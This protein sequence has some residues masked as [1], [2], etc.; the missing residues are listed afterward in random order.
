M[1]IEITRVYALLLIPI[2]VLIFYLI[3]K[4][5]KDVIRR[6]KFVLISRILILILIIAGISDITI[7]LRGKNVETV[8]LLDVSD[9]MSEFKDE[10]LKFIDNSLKEQPNHNKCGVILFGN[11]ASVDKSM[12][13]NKEYREIKSLPISIATNIEEAINTSFSLFNKGSSKRIVLITD[14]EENKGDMLKSVNLLKK[15]NVDL[16]VYKV[17]NALGDEVYIDEVSVPDNIA[18]DEE[19]SV[20]TKIQSNVQTKVKLT[21]FSGREKK[22]EQEVQV[23][24][25]INTFVFKDIQTSGGFKPYR[26]LIEPEKDS[27]SNNNEYS[28]FTNV[29]S[30]P[31]ILVIEGNEN[32]ALGVIETLRA[33]NSEFTTISP[34]TSP[35]TLNEMLEYKTIVL[36]DVHIDDLSSGFVDNIETYVKDYGGGLVTF[37]GENSYAL[38][39]Y[40]DTNLEKV[41]PVNMDKKGK[42]EIPQISISLVIDKSGSMSS[43]DGKVSKL[44]LAKEA[45][46]KSLDNLRETD[47]ISVI[48]FDDKYQRV[49]ERQNPK[50]KEEIKE[51]ISGIGEGGGTSIYPALEEAYKIQSESGAKIK[52]II[53]LTDGQDGFGLSNYEE[54]INNINNG[55]ITLSTV[56]VGED[57]DSYLLEELAVRGQGRTYHTDGFTDIPRIFAKEVLLST[58]TYIINEEFTPK[59]VSNNEVLSGVIND[60]S[61]PTLLGYIGTSTKDKA[62][63]V[64]SSNH[65][66]PILAIWQYGLGKSASWTSDINGQWSGHFLTW[67]KGA[68]LFK[69]I[70]YSTIEEFSND[71][72]ISITQDG[73]EAVIEFYT[74][75]NT[76][77]IKING[78]Y[79]SENGQQGQVELKQEEP[80]KFTGKVSLND[81]GFYNFNIRE[82]SNGEV[83]NNYNG[84]FSLQYSDEYKFNNNKEKLDTLVNELDG[85]II[86]KPKEVFLGEMKTSIRAI[87]LTTPLVILA[88]FLFL[89][90]IVYRRLNIDLSLYINKMK[91]KVN[92]N[93][94]NEKIKKVIVENKV[95]FHQK[96][97]II[98]T[99]NEE[100]NRAKKRNDKNK[101][102][103]NEILDTSAL[104]KNKNKR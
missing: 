18:I 56:S 7:N 4:K 58:G 99:D 71:G 5:L 60:N 22:C 10:G 21:L 13:N 12:D 64:I 46:M 25:G 11:N 96:Q 57:A 28:S 75:S 73:N 74:E 82:E 20:V 77:G 88:I 95:K 85:K 24:K 72:K 92:K 66:E 6:D 2:V 78:V 81:L 14:G 36:C 80:G 102:D 63:E 52:H 97:D 93:D 19:F 76:S 84:A 67:D 17:D 15:E 103:R 38:G 9:S 62:I 61:V 90:D 91:I 41:L 53:L 30:K 42:N 101:K 45:A 68:Q 48:A 35:N 1:G 33:S 37:G 59:I 51:M 43:G 65:D 87:N 40:K 27:N 89:L 83:I 32:S 8:F 3:S 50:D 55:G 26:V 29:I 47:E 49:V 86:N 16:K 23:E 70:I 39:G 34:M 98:K 94:T 79:N 54:L 100:R 31:N 69:N 44:T 104:L